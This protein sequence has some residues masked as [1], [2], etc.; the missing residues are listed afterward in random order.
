MLTHENVMAAII[1]LHTFV[2][3]YECDLGPDDAFLSFLPLA[4][5]FDRC[6]RNTPLRTRAPGPGA[7][8]AC[9]HRRRC[10]PCSAP[11]PPCVPCRAC[12]SATARCCTPLNPSSRSYARWCRRQTIQTCWAQTT[13]TSPSS[14]SPTSLTGQHRAPLPPCM[15]HSLAAGSQCGTPSF[16]KAFVLVTF[17]RR[18]LPLPPTR[19]RPLAPPP[20]TRPP[21]L[22][23][24]CHP[25]AAAPAPP[26]PCHSR[27][28]AS[29]GSTGRRLPAAAAA[30]QPTACGGAQ[31]A[32]P[33]TPRPGWQQSAP[34]LPLPRRPA[35][36]RPRVWRFRTALW[37]PP[38][39]PSSSSSRHT[40]WRSTTATASSPSCRWLTSLTGGRAACTAQRAA[41]TAGARG[42]PSLPPL[43]TRPPVAP[44]PVLSS[45]APRRAHSFCFWLRASL[46]ALLFAP[47]FFDHL[48]LRACAAP[49]ADPAGHVL[50][51]CFRCRAAEELFLHLGASIGYWRGD[52]KGLMEDIGKPCCHWY[53]L[54]CRCW[55]CAPALL[56]SAAD[57]RGMG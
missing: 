29:T 18:P 33:R 53:C 12:C 26:L 1:T 34:P 11:A 2:M 38:P 4:H 22:H 46:R 30:G 32:P 6:T 36:A 42:P 45:A 24:P 44:P 8:P 21:D 10:A 40:K 48:A 52:I 35:S 49:P 25:V 7:A 20:P 31:R 37:W 41:C 56:A 28:P 39:C 50:P 27:Q 43:P 3:E 14:R 23:P 47:R 5:I 13:A 54:R 57:R 55:C 51:L 19:R 17:A 16:L 9:Q 15:L